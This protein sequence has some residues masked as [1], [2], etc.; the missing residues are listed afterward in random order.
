MAKCVVHI[1]EMSV[2][3]IVKLAEYSAVEAPA[4]R[5]LQALCGRQTRFEP[6]LLSMC[7]RLPRRLVVI[8]FSPENED[9]VR[10][11]APGSIK[12]ELSVAIVELVA[13]TW[14]GSIIECANDGF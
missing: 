14:D 8:A 12:A 11:T 7:K 5:F 3:E 4:S 2:R 10:R 13:N 1:V 9:E 6:A